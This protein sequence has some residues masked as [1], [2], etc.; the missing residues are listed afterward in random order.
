MPVY[1]AST[2]KKLTDIEDFQ[3]L[4][5][6]AHFLL[7]KKPGFAELRALALRPRRYAP[8]L[9]PSRS[10]S[11]GFATPCARTGRESASTGGLQ[12]RFAGSSLDPLMDSLLDTSRE[13]K[14][15]KG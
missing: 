3:N 15:P 8:W 7:R 9:N 11:A 1:S 12:T 4:I 14:H 5:I 10:K 13:F 6:W 2:C